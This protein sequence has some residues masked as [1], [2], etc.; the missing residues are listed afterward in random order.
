LA[1]HWQNPAKSPVISPIRQFLDWR[2]AFARKQPASKETP[3]SGDKFCFNTHFVS[4][5]IRI[6]A[7]VI[8]G[9]VN[10][11]EGIEER[12]ATEDRNDEHRGIVIDTS[13]VRIMK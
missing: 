10:K 4:K 9:A 2:K 8:A 12:K 5:S 11:V 13:I 6:K 3:K 7:P 1:I